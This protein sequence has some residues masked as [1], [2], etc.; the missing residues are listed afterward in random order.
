LVHIFDL[1]CHWLPIGRD[2]DRF[3]VKLLI[4]SNLYF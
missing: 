3:H 4:D 2:H 1:C